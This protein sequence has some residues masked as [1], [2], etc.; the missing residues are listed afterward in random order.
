M[1]MRMEWVLMANA[2]LCC[3]PC[4]RLRAC[5][6]LAPLQQS[7]LVLLLTLLQE[8]GRRASCRRLMLTSLLD[9]RPTSV[10]V[11]L[12]AQSHAA[13]LTMPTVLSTV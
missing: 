7:P 1:P 11:S 5:R 9:C 4:P 13:S 6:M 12:A 8:R 2:L 3:Q 10:C